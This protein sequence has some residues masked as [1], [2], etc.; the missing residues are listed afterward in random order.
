M[1]MAREEVYWLVRNRWTFLGDSRPIL[2]A[3][4]SETPVEFVRVGASRWRLDLDGMAVRREIPNLDWDRSDNL[5]S[6]MILS[7]PAGDRLQPD[8][9][10]VA[11]YIRVSPV[12]FRSGLEDTMALD[13]AR[14][15][16]HLYARLHLASPSMTCVVSFRDTSTRIVDLAADEPNTAELIMVRFD[17]LPR[18][19]L[20]SP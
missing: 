18:A 5:R 7:S 12:L 13:T 6:I 9:S 14:A 1:A 4:H 2:D 16:G 15:S 10:R 20:P 3:L 17:R 11:Y 8:R 19:P